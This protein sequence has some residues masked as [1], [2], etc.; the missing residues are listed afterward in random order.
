MRKSLL[1]MAAM[2]AVSVVLAGKA[3]A[4]TVALDD[5]GFE[6]IATASAFDRDTTINGQ[7]NPPDTGT[8]SATVIEKEFLVLFAPHVM[9][10]TFDETD[11][12]VGAS[13]YAL[14]WIENVQNSTGSPI[15]KYI[16]ELGD[17]GGSFFNDESTTWGAPALVT[18]DGTSATFASN[19]GVSL[20]N[21][22]KRVEFVFSTPVQAGDSFAIY[23]PIWGLEASGS[24]TISQTA[25][26]LPAAAWGGMALLGGIGAIRAIR[27][28]K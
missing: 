20:S 11:A 24:F 17:T 28:R 12:F 7:T 5:T 22:G 1:A 13:G 6:A 18:Y 15:T 19:D 8:F 2:A 3:S 23:A 4:A 10:V 9:T 16:V 27:R 21:G 25:I 14:R 26:P